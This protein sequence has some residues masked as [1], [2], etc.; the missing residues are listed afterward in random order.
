MRQPIIST[1]ATLAFSTGIALGNDLPQ[2]TRPELLRSL[3]GHWAMIGDVRGKPVRYTLNV[4]PI[5]QG[6][7]SELHMKDVNI[8]AKYEAKVIIGPSEDG[9]SLVVHW[10]D[11]FGASYS[12]PHGT[13]FT[14][15]NVIEFSFPYSAGK[16]RDVLSKDTAKN[17]WSLKIE[18]EQK[19]GTWKHF[20]Q[21]DITPE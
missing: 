9:A 3:D 15:K 12:V 1:I 21:Y 11:S 4:A 6:K 8:P 13:G 18:A 16:F 19:D 17:S 14:S 5:L 7:Y 2:D 10:L 20:A